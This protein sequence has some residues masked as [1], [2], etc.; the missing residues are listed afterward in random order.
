MESLKDVLQR[1]GQ[2]ATPGDPSSLQTNEQI[3]ARI[4]AYYASMGVHCVTCGGYGTV[5]KH[6]ERT[7][8]PWGQLYV[9][10][11]TGDPSPMDEIT[12]VV[13]PSCKGV[14]ETAEEAFARRLSQ[15]GIETVMADAFRFKKWTHGGPMEHVFRQVSAFADHPAGGLVLAGP[16]G[17]GKTHLAIAAGVECCRRGLLVSFGESRTILGALKRGIVDGTY[18]DVFDLYAEC[19]LLII[20]DYG[21]ERQTPFAEDVL[22]EMISYRYARE[23]PFIVTTNVGARSADEPNGLTERIVSRFTDR[24]RVTLL[25]CEGKDMRPEMER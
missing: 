18:Q 16:K 24:S 10:M 1:V 7:H 22:E 2:A 13:C 21:V 8:D 14:K 17:V 5:A 6:S 23:R 12:Q 9:D 11:Q 19:S 15:S 3:E 4:A 20:D 25:R